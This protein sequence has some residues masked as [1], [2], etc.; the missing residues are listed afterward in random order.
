MRRFSASKEGHNAG[1]RTFLS[2]CVRHEIDKVIEG[3]TSRSIKATDD[4]LM[5]MMSIR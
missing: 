2:L 1:S 3:G 5:M 4:E